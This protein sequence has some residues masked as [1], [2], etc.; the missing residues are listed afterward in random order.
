MCRSSE[1][2]LISSTVA[3]YTGINTLTDSGRSPHAKKFL[4][5][6][7]L[8]LRSALAMAAATDTGLLR[9]RN[10]DSVAI[11]AAHGVALLADGMGGYN[12]GDVASG[13]TVELLMTGLKARLDTPSFPEQSLESVVREEVAKSNAIVYGAALAQTQYAGM[14][15]TL[16]LA[17]F[18]DNQI[19]C[20]HIGDS[21]LYRLRGETFEQLTRDH[22]LYQEQVDEGVLSENELANFQHKNLVTRALGVDPEV[23]VDINTYPAQVGDIYLL[24]SDG[25][26]DMASVNDIRD[27]I[28]LK[29]QHLKQAAQALIKL[30]NDYG[31]R[32]NIAVALIKVCK[33]FPAHSGFFQSISKRLFA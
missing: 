16:V 30:A 29:R 13:M 20:A 11:D 19:I 3:Y 17:V 27:T 26:T 14:G 33:P 23:E 6:W 21:R 4:S 25:L 31:G 32:D 1:E 10:E 2:T 18:R 7:R 12:A 15:T 22:S 8:R 5:I 28:Y 24:C 9:T